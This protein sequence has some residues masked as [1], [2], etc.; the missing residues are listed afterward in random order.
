MDYRGAMATTVEIRPFN[1]KAPRYPRLL[2]AKKNG[3][4]QSRATQRAAA[5]ISDAEQHLVEVAPL[6]IAER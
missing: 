5:A 1:K 2:S 4:R 3:Q 6:E